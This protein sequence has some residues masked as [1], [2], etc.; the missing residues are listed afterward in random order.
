MIIY[1]KTVET[2][3]LDS[4]DS[5][6]YFQGRRLNL[7]PLMWNLYYHLWPQD[8]FSPLGWE[9]ILSHSQIL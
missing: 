5:Q 1:F 3:L 7:L 9:L 2:G 8:F 4:H 6:I